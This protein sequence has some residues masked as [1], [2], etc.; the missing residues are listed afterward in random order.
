MEDL[1][2]RV[3]AIAQAF[4]RAEIPHSFGGAI[5]LGYYAPA[6][7]TRDIDVNVYLRVE[8]AGRA[9]DSLQELGIPEA[10]DDQRAKI[11]RDGQ[12]RLYWDEVPLDLFFWN[13]EF[14]AS[15]CE[16]RRQYA[17]LDH[18]IDILSPEDLIVCKVAFARDK[19]TRDISQ[20]LDSMGE[21]L[22]VPYVLHW[23]EAIVGTDAAPA[24]QLTRALAQ[25]SLLPDP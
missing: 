24:Q 23:V 1:L 16:R 20:M 9:L 11:R 25:R 13:L 14:H 3:I 4:G 12:T 10:N 2:E 6:R 15:C 22:D 19:D 17:L 8:D 21:R 5:A 18:T 7:P